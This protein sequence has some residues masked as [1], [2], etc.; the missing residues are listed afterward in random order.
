[1]SY[2]I[3]VWTALLAVC[4]C[5]CVAAQVPCSIETVR[6]VWVHATNLTTVIMAAPGSS[7]PVAAPTAAL[8]MY[9]IDEQG[10]LTGSSNRML[11]GEYSDVTVAGRVEVNADCT[12]TIRFTMTPLGAQSPMPGEA[13]SRIAVVDSGNEMMAMTVAGIIGNS[14]GGE[15]YRRIV[16]NSQAAPRCTAE[17]VSGTYAAGGPGI[18]IALMPAPGQAQPLTVP[19][20]GI[21]AV[22]ID[23]RGGVT[24]GVTQSV[25]GQLVEQVM[26]ANSRY[27]VFEDCT[28]Y[29]TFRLNPKGVPGTPSGPP[30]MEKHIILDN[31]AEIRTLT[32]AAPGV[33]LV[34]PGVWKRM[35]KETA[36][37]AW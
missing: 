31:G 11:A 20:S 28:A 12:G 14:I 17:T 4:F 7:Q 37:V 2:R 26:A 8:G 34:T 10:R 9:T 5:S 35:S 19:F 36:P 21:G 16:R 3:L 30:S 33:K 1:M 6:G 32:L 29:L 27:D 24:G 22:V 25:G 15:T 23:S 13:V 18:G